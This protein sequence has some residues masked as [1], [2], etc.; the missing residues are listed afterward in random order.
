MLLGAGVFLMLSTLGFLSVALSLIS[1]DQKNQGPISAAKPNLHLLIPAH[2]EEKKISATLESIQR[3]LTGFSSPLKITVG[4]DNCTD[5]TE[6]IVQS[7][8]QRLPVVGVNFNFASKWKTLKKLL[9]LASPD[10]DWILFIDA[11]TILGEGSLSALFLLMQN[12]GISVL[13]PSYRVRG[14]GV[15]H[16][17]FWRVESAL[18][19]LENKNGGPM[20]V[21]GATVAYRKKVI[22]AIFSR[23]SQE[24][25]FKNDDVIGP[26]AA[27]VYFP[28]LQVQY[29]PSIF[30]YDQASLEKLDFKT[31]WTRRKRMVLGNLQWIRWFTTHE[32]SVSFTLKIISLRRI[33][34]PFWFCSL[35]ILSVG[36]FGISHILG[37]I[38]LIPGFLFPS[39]AL[40][41]LYA[42]YAL[43]LGLD[44]KKS[45]WR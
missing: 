28:E 20:S 45:I 31:Q 29:L 4:L 9:S 15:V 18:K 35:L 36:L 21:H 1:S 33:L 38:A 22:E 16:E 24:N 13:A 43:I 42:P 23:L 40:A 41:S 2:N 26:L 8:S 19:N 7:W 3:E 5:Q 10:A 32:E 25:E 12:E 30:V 17:S 14:G 6:A 11:G 34:R 27:R 39:A 37:V 44:Q